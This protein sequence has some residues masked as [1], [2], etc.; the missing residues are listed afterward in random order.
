MPSRKRFITFVAVIQ[1]I[2]FL[3][4][5]FLYE[6][7]TFS[8]QGSNVLSGLGFKS[9]VGF[10]SVSFVRRRSSPS[11]TRMPQCELSTGLRRFGWVWLLKTPSELKTQKFRSFVRSWWLP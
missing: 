11:G 4:H 2:L 10:L 3:A 9:A 7:W 1:A 5:S 6:T 8:A